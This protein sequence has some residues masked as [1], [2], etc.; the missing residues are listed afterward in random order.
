[1]WEQENEDYLFSD[2]VNGN[3]TIIKGKIRSINADFYFITFNRTSSQG[4]C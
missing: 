4:D 3:D 2:Y 1:M